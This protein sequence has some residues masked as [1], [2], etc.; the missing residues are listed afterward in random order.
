MLCLRRLVKQRAMSTVLNAAFSTIDWHPANEGQLPGA[1]KNDA[2]TGFESNVWKDFED[3]ED[4]V[5][6][7]LSD[8][9]SSDTSSSDTPAVE[10]RPWT[11]LFDPDD[12]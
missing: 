12:I 2:Q 8:T 1:G 11:E 5:Q 3:V 9:E 4:T 6:D 10:M 7:N